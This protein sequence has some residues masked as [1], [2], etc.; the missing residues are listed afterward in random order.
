MMSYDVINIRQKSLKLE[1]L[2]WVDDIS[3]RWAWWDD[4]KSYLLLCFARYDGRSKITLVNF[5]GSEKRCRK[6]PLPLPAL[7]DS[8]CWHLH[9]VDIS[10]L[11]NFF[12]NWIIFSGLISCFSFKENFAF[13]P[14]LALYTEIHVVIIR[15]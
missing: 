12:F 3:N 13:R 14:D 1:L 8:S 2:I 5:H 11:A 4:S 6:S 15:H 9:L 10:G 7:V